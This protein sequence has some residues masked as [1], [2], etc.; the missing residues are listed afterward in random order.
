MVA[1]RTAT[2][3]PCDDGGN[4]QVHAGLWEPRPRIRG[5]TSQDENDECYHTHDGRGWR[6]RWM[7]GPSGNSTNDTRR[8]R[9]RGSPT[10]DTR[11]ETH[12]RHEKHRDWESRSIP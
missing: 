9:N 3:R 5:E 1:I 4:V 6:A 10:R 2:G 7:S 8:A 11:S 12:G